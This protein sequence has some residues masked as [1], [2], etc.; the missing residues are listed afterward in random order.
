MAIIIDEIITE[1]Q[2]NG[3]AFNAPQ[4]APNVAPDAPLKLDQLRFELQR[5]AHRQ[6]R[7]WVD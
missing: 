5:D 3:N 7:I 6:A 1:P 2:P 4:A